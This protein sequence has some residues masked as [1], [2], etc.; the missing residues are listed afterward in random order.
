MTL[1]SRDTSVGE[2]RDGARMKTLPLLVTVISLVGCSPERADAPPKEEPRPVPSSLEGAQEAY[3]KSDWLTMD[4]RLRDVLVDPASSA[5]VRD[6]AFE[7]LDKAYEATSG[8]LPSRYTL[9]PYVRTITL[10]SMRG[11]HRWATY[12]TIF[13]YAQVEKGLG[14]HVQDLTVRTEPDHAVVLDRATG[15]GKWRVTPREKFDEVLLELQNAAAPLP[16][17]VTTLR[18]SLDD[19]RLVDTW[20]FVRGLGS[21]AAPEVTTPVP[22]TTLSDPSPT[23][24]WKPFRSPEYAPFEDR[25]LSIYTSDDKT[26]TTAL[27][28]YVWQPGE[29]SQWKV[30]KKLAPGSYWVAFTMQ[31]ERTFG[32]IRLARNSQRGIPFTI[33]P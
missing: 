1:L 21:S 10:G 25:A 23:F 27:D 22:E 30:D 28:H 12:R 31:E 9:P 20:T 6:N 3:L 33:V 17:G 32:A 7:L 16:D 14:E 29:L 18:L 5:L 13:F 8:K 26:K 15:V 19:G 24:E 4:D 2:T 11:E